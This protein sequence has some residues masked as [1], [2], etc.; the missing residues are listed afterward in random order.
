MDA[1]CKAVLSSASLAITLRA[2]FSGEGVLDQLCEMSELALHEENQMVHDH[3]HRIFAHNA[4]VWEEYFA[5]RYAHSVHLDNVLDVEEILDGLWFVPEEKLAEK[6]RRM[7]EWD[8]VNNPVPDKLDNSPWKGLPVFENVKG[9]D[10]KTTH[11]VYPRHAKV[12][13]TIGL[14]K[15][16]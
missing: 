3:N 1:I 6:T 12:L 10:G 11:R 9:A 7:A 13:R 4:H 2:R 16:E 8:N 15:T 5:D 14:L